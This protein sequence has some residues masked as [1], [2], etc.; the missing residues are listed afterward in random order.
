MT[1][2]H[3][4][5]TRVDG[6]ATCAG[7]SAMISGRSR[8]VRHLS[9]EL[10]QARQELDRYG[11]LL[12]SIQESILPQQLPD[13]PSLGLALHSAQVDGA[14]GDFYHIRQVGSNRWAFVIADVSGHGLAATA[15]LVLVH[16]LGT[17]VQGEQEP[18]AAL[19][20]VNNPLA[21][22]Y[23]ANTGEFVT[24]FVAVYD[25]QALT[26]TYASAGHPPPRLVRGNEVR[27]L[28][29]VSEL[30]LGID[31][32]SVYRNESLQL[33]AGD[34]LVLFTDGITESA[35]R[36]REFF[37]DERLDAVLAGPV[38]SAAELVKQVVD[39]AKTFRA[40]CPAIDDE[41]CL[42]ALVKPAPAATPAP[43]K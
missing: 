24:A 25:T 43:R 10:R 21:T 23:L 42:V 36:A 6:W 38:N 4:N 32:T 11:T 16:A 22:R 2:R 15:I 30:P 1:L 31:K 18:G 40:G 14:G 9:D 7:S 33:Q 17:A 13:V 8:R 3:N 5:R 19:A 26:L 41:T 34:R 12:L 20:L 27:R 29:A 39:S 28:D 35:N 37:G